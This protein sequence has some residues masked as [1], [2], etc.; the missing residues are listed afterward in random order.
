MFG[1]NKN[2]ILFWLQ[3]VS[4]FLAT[5]ISVNTISRLFAEGKLSAPSIRSDLKK[6]YIIGIVLIVLLTIGV[7][8]YIREQKRTRENLFQ[9]G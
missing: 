6:Y 4:A 5:T 1:A 3:L 9:N 8:I 2:D 7:I